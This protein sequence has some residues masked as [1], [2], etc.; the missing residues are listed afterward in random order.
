MDTAT[1]GKASGSRAAVDVPDSPAMPPA[2]AEAPAMTLGDVIE[3]I[4]RHRHAGLA[5]GAT[6][7]VLVMVSAL[8]KTPM[9]EAQ[10]TITLDRGR[11]P[12]EFDPRSQFDPFTGQYEH[13]LLNTQRTI[14]LS[15]N[16]L[17]SALKTGGLQV[18][19]D[20]VASPDAVDRLRD[21]LNVA[22]SRDS[23][24]LAVTL[25][26]E[27]PRRAE[28]GLQ[29]VIDAFLARQA[30]HEK[31]RTENSIAFLQTQLAD[32]KRKMEQARDEQQ[33]FQRDND[34]LVLDPEKSFPAQRLSALNSKRVVLSQQIAAL[35]T[36][37]DQ[38]SAID[39][40]PDADSRL[41]A[42]LGLEL[43]NRHPTVSEQ[44]KLLYDLKTQEALLAQKFLDKHPRLVEIRSQIATK[45]GHLSAAVAAVR[46]GVLSDYSKL[47]AQ[48]PSLS[49]AI[50]QVE[51]EINTY[52][53]NLFRL[54][55]LAQQTKNAD[56]LYEQ[57]LRRL[58]EER[59][60]HQ[61]DAQQLSVVDSPRAGSRPVNV[62][63]VLSLAVA[64]V[65]GGLGCAGVPL[66][67]E[68]FGR[69]AQGAN[70][71]RELTGL[72][73]L[74]ELPFVP[75]LEPLGAQGDPNTIA[76]LAEGFRGLRTALRLS[77]RGE[78]GGQCLVITSCD[79]GEG[80]STVSTRLA[81][82]MA[83]SG[84]RVLLIDGDLRAPAL[85]GQLGQSCDRGLGELLAGEPGVAPAVTTYPNLDFVDAG[86]QVANPG[87]LLNSHCLPEWLEQCR[88]TYDYIIIDT[89]PLRWFADALAIGQH[90]DRIM[91]VVRLGAT[92]KTSLAKAREQ[93]SPLL[94]KLLGVVLINKADALSTLGFYGYDFYAEQRPGQP[95]RQAAA[96]QERGA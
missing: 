91:L 70:H 32:A 49:A 41:E 67:L 26:D 73:V 36:L 5:A 53:E 77:S 3:I 69:R 43:V 9:Y 20:Y 62:N 11:R 78:Q 16:V 85:A 45:R 87:E 72:A 58:S 54:Q 74:G 80:K 23:W 2:A 79:K 38:I 22:T 65:L 84:L 19:E 56:A 46:T 59:V 52:R 30:G 18:H 55:T 50:K 21:R 88:Q 64:L 82:S 60:T 66:V 42:M 90:G 12:V 57:L 81:V 10:A 15:R 39:A 47:T 94:A 7:A 14:L 29:A 86:A 48:L 34:L 92:F 95:R 35:Q 68:F 75:D 93:L 28:A 1:L 40:L 96:P 17:E 61:L 31:E 6:L 4:K 89:P 8:L 33:A 51:G 24:D 13:D 83:Q 63:L 37:V 27:D 44:Q 25:R 71:I 76:K